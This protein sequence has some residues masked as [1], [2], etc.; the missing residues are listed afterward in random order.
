MSTKKDTAIALLATAKSLWSKEDMRSLIEKACLLL[1]D[2]PD[3][4]PGLEMA[5]D[6]IGEAYARLKY[7]LPRY[8]DQP[9]LRAEKMAICESALLQIKEYA[10]DGLKTRSQGSLEVAEEIVRGRL[11]HS[12]EDFS[13]P[14]SAKDAIEEFR[15]LLEETGSTA[16][17]KTAEGE[18][19]ITPE[20][21]EAV[22]QAIANDPRIQA[23]ERGE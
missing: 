20:K 18:T 9:Y 16:T 22:E 3:T 13:R 12:I 5:A 14:A 8:D 1:R 7:N 15:D 6:M 11:N 23:L 17:I 21:L 2:E 4:V 19:E 10:S